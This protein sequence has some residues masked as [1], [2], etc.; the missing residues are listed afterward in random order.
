MKTTRFSWLSGN[1]CIR[2]SAW[3]API[4]HTFLIHSHS[5]I[6][7]RKQ[8][9]GTSAGEN[10][11]IPVKNITRTFFQRNEQRQLN[12][13]LFYTWTKFASVN[14]VNEWMYPCLHSTWTVLMLDL[15]H[16]FVFWIMPV[17][18]NDLVGPTDSSKERTDA[19][20]TLHGVMLIEAMLNIEISSR[21][22]ISG[23]SL[24]KHVHARL[25]REKPQHKASL[26]TTKLRNT[27]D[28]T[29]HCLVF[30]LTSL[31]YKL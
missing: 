18:L 25:A 8:K 6:N 14:T 21:G 4:L 19:S 29:L 1:T 11:A 9:C 16:T 12:S 2:G 3:S 15:A 23:D 31:W 24:K 27:S 20:A 13:E 30:N 17:R 10:I 5:T 22:W 7:H 28:W 26:Y